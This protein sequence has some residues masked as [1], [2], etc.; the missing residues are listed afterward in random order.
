MPRFRTP[1][2]ATALGLSAFC[3]CLLLAATLASA[4]TETIIHNFQQS[5]PKDGMNPYSG[6]IA[7]PEGRL[8]GNAW[9]VGA[10]D[11]GI[12][13]AMAPPTTSGESW[14][15]GILYN[16]GE[17]PDG[18]NPRGNILRDKNGN[19]YGTT[20]NGGSYGCGT[21]YELSPPAQAGSKWAETILHDFDCTQGATDGADPTA[22]VIFDDAGN[23]WG[24]TSGGGT[25]GLGTVFELASPS[26]SGGTWTETVVYNFQGNPDGSEPF[27]TLVYA[28]HNK[29]YGLTPYGGS[30]GHGTFY[31]VWSDG[32]EKVIHSFLNKEDGGSPAGTP[33][34]DGHGNVYGSDNSGGSTGNGVVFEFTPPTGDTGWTGKILYDFLGTDGSSCQGL[35]FDSTG[36]LYGSTWGGGSAGFGTVFQLT[37]PTS[38]GQWSETVLHNF[39]GPPSDGQSVWTAPVVVDG[40]LYGVTYKGGAENMG[41]VFAVT[42]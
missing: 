39:A 7:D 41:T 1:L 33:I 37:P 3:A 4:Q 9:M 30:D 24:T 36:A 8:Y 28:G 34:L 14:H 23:L 15:Y 21:V 18:A 16:F 42:P 27:G 40:V 10:S 35:V 32:T 38:R 20:Q 13:F 2:F 17:A 11:N 22:G 6:L 29:F 25:A 31:E 19:L 26:T 5:N 12:V